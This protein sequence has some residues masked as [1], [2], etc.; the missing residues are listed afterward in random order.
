MELKRLLLVLRLLE[1]I[2]IDYMVTGSIAAILY[3]KPRLTHDM[4]VVVA[5][6][7]ANISLF[8]RTFSTDEFYC[9]PL[10]TLA[11]EIH[12]GTRGQFNVIDNISGFKVDFY[13]MGNDPLILWGFERK[14]NIELL[15]NELVWVA[16]P[17][18][19]ILKKLQYYKEGGS[20]KHLEDIKAI[21]DV[22]GDSVDKTGVIPW[23]KK[24]SIFDLWN[25][26]V[27]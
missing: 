22:S 11:E 2:H 3:G 25:Q 18:Y 12:R 27:S 26:V 24:L 9:P 6:P 4:D 17:E 1:N 16:P 19:V 13:P 21:L 15:P 14:K 20:Q 5:F 7:S 23:A 8:H 10:E